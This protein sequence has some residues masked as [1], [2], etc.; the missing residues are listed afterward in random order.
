MRDVRFSRLVV[1]IN[2]AVPGALLAW[3]ALHHQLGA[4]PVNFAILTT[5]MLTLTFLSLTLLVTPLRRLSGWN[6]LIFFRR[7]LGLYAFFY[8]SA[9]FLIFFT[10]DRAMSLASTGAEMVKR[11][12]LVIGSLGLTCMVPLA[13]TSTNAMI[14]RLSAKRWHLLHRLVYVAAVAGVVHFYMQAKADKRLP[15]AFAVT[16]GGLL[17]YRA[18]ALVLDRRRKIT[19]AKA[20]P[21]AEIVPKLPFGRASISASPKFSGNVRKSGLAGTLALPGVGSETVSPARPG[22]WSGQLRVA[23]VVQETHNVRTFRLQAPEGG[24]LPFQY[25]PGQYLNLSLLIDGK[26]VNRSYTIASAPTRCATCELTIKREEMGVAS[27]HLHDTLREGDL[28]NVSAPAGRFTFRGTEADSIVLIG[29]GVGITPLMS[30]LRALTDRYWRGDIYLVYCVRQEREIIFAQELES[31]RQQHPNLHLCLAVSR[32]DGTQ[33]AGHRGRITAELLRQAIPDLPRRLFFICGPSAMMSSVME[34]LRTLGVPE[35][36]I[37]FEA[38]VYPTR[39]EA[40]PAPIQTTAGPREDG[41]VPRQAGT[42]EAAAEGAIPTVSFSVS[43]KTTRLLLGQTVLE[44]GEVAGLALEDECGSGICGTCKKRLLAGS[45]TME[46]EDALSPVDK[47][48]RMILLCQ[49]KTTGPVT[50]EA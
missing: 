3:D 19:A 11:P 15:V 27:R 43:G 22:F 1:L 49:A 8:A 4:N 50:V 23:R 7:T 13:V 5:G 45:V 6:W 29:G 9:H 26:R 46:V 48:D 35:S 44:A 41:A 10:L 16:V 21:A 37:K 39:A 14:K 36:R 25:L 20:A 28:L 42:A 34:L 32:P 2:C 12:Y 38:F 24:D 30:I 47:A 40:A 33:W 18:V 31:L 17:A